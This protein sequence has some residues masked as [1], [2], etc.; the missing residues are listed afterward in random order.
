[1]IYVHIL[2][3][4]RWYIN[5][6][7]KFSFRFQPKHPQSLLKQKPVTHTILVTSTSGL[8]KASEV[9]STTSRM[10]SADLVKSDPHVSLI[11]SQPVSEKS[12]IFAKICQVTDSA[13]LSMYLA[14]QQRDLQY[15]ESQI[16]FRAF[17]PYFKIL[18]LYKYIK[19]L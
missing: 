13:N 15:Q 5:I 1:M 2:L 16:P 17:W 10:T 18:L 4:L 9:T 11:S 3:P 6:F 8:T 12:Y 7:N 19:M 14:I